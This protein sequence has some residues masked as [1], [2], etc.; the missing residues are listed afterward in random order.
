MLQT[1]FSIA[2]PPQ[3]DIDQF[4]QKNFDV[5]G[6]RKSILVYDVFKITENFFLGKHW[7]V[8]YKHTLNDPLSR[9]SL[10]VLVYWH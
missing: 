4:S 5:L 9:N 7:Q 1:A 3:N 10:I 8:T 2:L 6:V